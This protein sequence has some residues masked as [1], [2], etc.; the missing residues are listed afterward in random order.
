MTRPDSS[1]DSTAAF[2]LGV[3][4]LLL[5]PLL[6]YA[7]GV[8]LA[9]NITLTSVAAALVVF[10]LYPQTWHIG[11]LPDPASA[12]MLLFIAACGLPL[13]L[14]PGRVGSVPVPYA[15]HTVA[16]VVLCPLAFVAG[17]HGARG[18]SRQHSRALF[19]VTAGTAA[20]FVAVR[21]A[22]PEII[23]SDEIGKG[24]YYQYAGDCLALAALLAYAKGY[25][26]AGGWLY[27]AM[28]PLL[29]LLGSRASLA[30]YAVALLFTR[31]LPRVVLMGGALIAVIASMADVLVESLPEFY[32]L[33][34]V[35][36]SLALT[37][38]EGGEDA[39]LGE[40][41]EFHDQA[42]AT[43]ADHVVTGRYAYDFEING[44]V[45][46]HAH[47]AIDLWAQYGVVAFAAFVGALVANPLSRL[48][49]RLAMPRGAAPV[50]NS[51]R[52]IYA[53]L[54]IFLVMEFAFFRHPESVPLFFGIG[55]LAG[56]SGRP[57]RFIAQ[58]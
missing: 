23:S 49:D 18:M 1:T 9:V 5:V 30:S 46:G 38:V 48:I 54:L 32:D 7:N 12:A 52:V 45:G 8:G 36:T 17:T 42:V 4:V 20:L 40:R 34:R 27:L 24:S 16:L 51:D 19:L 25:R 13:L 28:L 35:V 44:Y 57:S 15:M 43:I 33:S 53:P 3:S 21:I 56:L 22:R 29:L 47:S 39:S 11:R 2:L 55:L 37:L 50:L 10:A 14:S 41:R 6:S 58:A 26:P 31:Y